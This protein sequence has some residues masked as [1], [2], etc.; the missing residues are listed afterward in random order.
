MESP[1]IGDIILPFV[2]DSPVEKAH[3]QDVSYALLDTTG[4][5][6]CGW[7]RDEAMQHAR[8][9]IGIR[10]PGMISAFTTGP[11]PM[12]KGV[13]SEGIILF[14]RILAAEELAQLAKEEATDEDHA[15]KRQRLKA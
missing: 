5:K 10:R 1:H 12:G 14:F 15:P 11:G 13:K 2:V 9:L 8:R 4:R 3:K 6:F 7:I